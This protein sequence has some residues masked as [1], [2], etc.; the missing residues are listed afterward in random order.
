MILN[1]GNLARTEPSDMY[2]GNTL[3]Y[4]RIQF[5]FFFLAKNQNNFIL[6]DFFND[7]IADPL[8]PGNTKRSVA[9][10]NLPRSPSGLYPS[11]CRPA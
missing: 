2:L 9:S 4:L 5:H 3:P 6:P 11:G 10:L 1:A 8:S 7:G